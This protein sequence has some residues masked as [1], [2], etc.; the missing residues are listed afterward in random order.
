MCIHAYKNT[1]FMTTF[2]LLNVIT[3][4]GFFALQNQNKHVHQ[5]CR[6]VNAVYSDAIF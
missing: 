5:I 2:T 4:L 3:G 1:Y 6:S